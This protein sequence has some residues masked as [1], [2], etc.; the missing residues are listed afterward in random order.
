MNTNSVMWQTH[1]YIYNGWNLKGAMYVWSVGES[2]LM[3]HFHHS[4]HKWNV[5]LF[6]DCKC[7]RILLVILWYI[8]T[9][10]YLCFLS[11]VIVI[12][13]IKSCLILVRYVKEQ[14]IDDNAHPP[15]YDGQVVCWV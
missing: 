15:S 7:V 6:D 9:V 5:A 14:L 1:P 12:V 11:H 4:M 3:I 8:D 10:K 13:N 2:Q